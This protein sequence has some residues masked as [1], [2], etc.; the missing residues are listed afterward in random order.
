MASFKCNDPATNGYSLLWASGLV[1][2]HAHTA[3]EDMSFYQSAAYACWLYMP[4]D[5]GEIIIEV[6]QRKAWAS[7]DRAVAVSQQSFKY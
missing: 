7:R 1:L 4:T 6:W 5:H 3:D 2:F